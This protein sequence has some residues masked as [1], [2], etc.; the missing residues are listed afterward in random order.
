MHSGRARARCAARCATAEK[1]RA[2]WEHSRIRTYVHTYEKM[3][4]GRMYVLR[5]VYAFVSVYAY[6]GPRKRHTH[7]HK[8]GGG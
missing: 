8:C 1:A 7:A 5:V 2:A 3:G 4:K 6:R